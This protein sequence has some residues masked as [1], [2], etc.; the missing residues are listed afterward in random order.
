M[1]INMNKVG[2][3]IKEYR[4]KHN[5]SLKD[6]EKLTGISSSSLQRYETVSAGRLSTEKLTIIAEALN[7][8]PGVLMGWESP[9]FPL[10]KMTAIQGL[11]LYNDMIMAYDENE[12]V[13][14]LSDIHSNY[15]FIAKPKDMEKLVDRTSSYFE[16][17]L[18]KII[19]KD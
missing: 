7:T 16:F 17:E 8:T 2:E 15:R 13:I 3:R 10:K 5:Y 9:E 6:L 14:V 4:Q 11:L 12:D 1:N 18:N 19:H